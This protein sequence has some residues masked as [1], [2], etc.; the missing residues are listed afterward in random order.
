MLKSLGYGRLFYCFVSILIAA[1]VIGICGETKPYAPT[2]LKPPSNGIGEEQTAEAFDIKLRFISLPSEKAADFFTQ[3][4][5]PEEVSC[6]FNPNI[7]EVLPTAFDGNSEGAIH[8]QS[9]LAAKFPIL[10]A[11]SDAVKFAQILEWVERQRD[12]ETTMTP[13][14]LAL[15]DQVAEVNTGAQRPFVVD[16]ENKDAGDGRKV[17]SP[18]VRSVD[19]G[20]N[21]RLKVAEHDNHLEL[22]SDLT[23]SEISHITQYTFQTTEKTGASIQIPHCNIHRTSISKQID[24]GATLVIDAN[25][26]STVN[27]LKTTEISIVKNIP[28]I[29]NI[30]K[31][32]T[33]QSSDQKILVF[34]TVDR[35][36]ANPANPKPVAN[37]ISAK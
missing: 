10:Y 8:C 3:F 29:R 16:V 30:A 7:S 20:M 33:H 26:V 4:F 17:L 24:A 12:V 18:I 27:R 19:E 5:K 34:I 9:T 31:Q 13:R 23:V 6:D 28:L 32:T 1:T 11:Q 22:K 21:V 36:P 14:I 37:T 15:P 25:I 2:L 35:K